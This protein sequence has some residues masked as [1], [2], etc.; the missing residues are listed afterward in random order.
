ARLIDTVDDM[1]SVS[2]A[3]HQLIEASLVLETTDSKIL[4]AYLKRSPA[5]ILTEHQRI[6][7]MI[8]KYQSN[9]ISFN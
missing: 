3:L 7:R 6:R 9:S 2:P 8:G 1:K 4:A 5:I